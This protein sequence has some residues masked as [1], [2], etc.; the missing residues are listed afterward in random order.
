MYKPSLI[1][2]VV[3]MITVNIAIAQKQKPL[4][5]LDDKGV[6]IDGYDPV[7]YF[8]ERKPVKGSVQFQATY[9]G[10]VYYFSSADNQKLFESDP[11]KYEVQFGGF[12]AYAVSQGHVS[13]IDPDFCIV[14]KNDAGIEKL[15]CQHNQ[16]A[17]DLWNKNPDGLLVNANKY[18]PAV[19]KN[20]GKQ[21]PVEGVEHFY[22]NIDSDGLANQGYDVVA[23]HTETKPV[24]GDVRFTEWFHGAKY[25]FSSKENQELFRSNPKQYLP[26]YGGFCAYAM[27]LGKIR[28]VDPEIFSIE[29]GRLM[30][31]HTRE[32]Y[33]LF[34]KDVK[35]S[36]KK[37]DTAWPGVEQKHAGKKVK[38]DKPAK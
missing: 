28:P 7:A 12:C 10:S 20:G 38:F 37:A 32:A 6:I 31:Q 29:D 22:I 26:Q 21:I 13:P 23:Y 16:K 14:Q 11:V 36:I 25:L 24:K 9:N 27:S 5:N 17:S 1:L 15:I 2:F 35:G 8:I 4:L 18:W 30:L 19:E 33:D 3:I 34:Y